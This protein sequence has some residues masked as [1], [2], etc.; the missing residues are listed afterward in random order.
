M[1]GLNIPVSCFTATAKPQVILDIKHYF[2]EQL[3]LELKLFSASV[4]RKNLQYQV[5][6][7]NNEEQK[8]QTLRE[9]IQIYDCPTIIYVS[10]TKKLQ[11]LP[12]NYPKTD[13]MPCPITAKW[14][15]N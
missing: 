13:L 12:R 1:V 3:D 6:P 2:K 9:L 7:Q 15:A 5:I 14:T 10:R 8:Y 11:R 4:E